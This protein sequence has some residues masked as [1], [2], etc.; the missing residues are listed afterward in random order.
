MPPAVPEKV[1]LELAALRER[2]SALEERAVTAEAAVAV[3]KAATA[4]AVAS[5]PAA[6]PGQVPQQQL[7]PAAVPQPPPS[8]TAVVH[9]MSSPSGQQLACTRRAV[10][11]TS[12]PPVHR[13][14]AAQA[15]G[16][17]TLGVYPPWVAR[18]SLGQA[19]SAAVSPGPPRVG[20]VW[21][22]AWAAGA[23]PSSSLVLPAAAASPSSS[24][25]L[26]ATCLAVGPGLAPSACAG[27]AASS[28]EPRTPMRSAEEPKRTLTAL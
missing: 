6:P 18:A 26:G 17:P 25:S 5:A 10:A 11:A 2:V 24:G 28:L 15:V 12:P 7:G 16:Q 22:R 8:A 23:A 1:Q 9:M 14:V 27:V 13:Q 19:A 4:A 3:A 20:G 21:R